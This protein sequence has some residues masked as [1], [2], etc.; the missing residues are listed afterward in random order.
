MK[1][2]VN[3]P[4][5]GDLPYEVLSNPTLDNIRSALNKKRNRIRAT[6]FILLL[7]LL[8]HVLGILFGD[9]GVGI[10]SNLPLFIRILVRY[11]AFVAIPVVWLVFGKL[12]RRTQLSDQEIMKLIAQ[13]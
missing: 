7:P 2:L 9:E 10:P 6:K 1:Q 12:E 11:F 8:I 13:E 4:I 5:L 3:H